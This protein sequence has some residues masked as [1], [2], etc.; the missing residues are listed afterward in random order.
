M[1]TN[2]SEFTE[3]CLAFGFSSC[4]ALSRE[5]WRRS[6]A[7]RTYFAVIK[8]ML[9][10]ARKGPYLS[11]ML[12]E[13]LDSS[14]EMM[15]CASI[16]AILVLSVLALPAANI[17]ELR[18]QLAILVST[19]KCKEA[20]G[21]NLTHEQVRRLD[22]KDVMKHYKRYESYVG[23][24]TTE[25]LIESFLGF[26]TK[27]LSLAVKLKDA[28]A[29]Q[30]ELKNDYIITKELSNLSGNLALRCGRLLAVANVFLITAK[31]V[32]FSAEEPRH[33][34]DGYPLAGQDE[35][36]NAKQSSVISE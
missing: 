21:V 15:L 17:P 36:P 30:N 12:P 32:D 20:I 11:E 8:N 6:S 16:I 24:K 3:D 2:H 7:V 27:A 5:G 29:L 4:P 28:E 9:A 14:F 13:R 26:F 18:E 31:H 33:D 23:A 35:V 10:T 1:F 25:T 22:E 34:Q 19:G